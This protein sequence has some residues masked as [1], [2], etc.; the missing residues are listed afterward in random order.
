MTEST[1]PSVY[2]RVCSRCSNS[3]TGND[4]DTAGFLTS[5]ASID[6]EKGIIT[7]ICYLCS[8]YKEGEEKP[9]PSDLPTLLPGTVTCNSHTRTHTQEGVR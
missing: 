4:Q 7:G 5:T 9:A 8:Q 3:I 6:E 1:M 2:R